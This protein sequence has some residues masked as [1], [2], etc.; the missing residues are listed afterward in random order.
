MKTELWLL[1][2]GSSKVLVYLCQT[3]LLEH[4]LIIELKIESATMTKSYKKLSFIQIVNRH[5]QILYV[6]ALG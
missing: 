1:F 6:T 3:S 2:T 4:M 5:W